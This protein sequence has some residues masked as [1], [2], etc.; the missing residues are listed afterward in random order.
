M[1]THR[2]TQ[3]CMH[4]THRVTHIDIILHTVTHYKH[5]HIYSTHKDI[6]IHHTPQTHT[7]IDRQTKHIIY[8]TY[9]CSQHTL[10]IHM[11]GCMYGCMF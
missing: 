5:I 2:E 7:N 6:F 3:T 4:Y 8:I 10:Y 11:Y 9:I 1:N